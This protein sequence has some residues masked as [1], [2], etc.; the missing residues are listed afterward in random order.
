MRNV[1]SEIVSKAAEVI[2][3]GGVLL[4]PTDTIYGLGCDALNGAAIQR[5]FEIKRRADDKPA[6]VL[7]Q[8][9]AMLDMLA[10][11]FPPIASKLAKRFWPGPLTI[12]FKS[13]WDLHPLLTGSGGRV[14]VRIPDNDFCRR[15]LK[16][17]GVP[18]VSTSANIS[19]TEGPGDIG[20]L[21]SL[22]GGLVDLV[23]DAGEPAS[24]L[25]STVVDVSHGILT[26]VR[27]GVI[28]AEA[29]REVVDRKRPAT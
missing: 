6:L 26:I 21:R 25:P 18:I 2:R 28:P 19:G 29:V 24:N 3:K 16:E 9:G 10:A 15:L 27:E 1:A 8:D 20:S 23:V 12:I 22:F 7:I 14:G 13:R 17:T 5:V 4:Y 11:E